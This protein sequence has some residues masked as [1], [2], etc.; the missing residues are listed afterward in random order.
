MFGSVIVPALLYE[1]SIVKS[2]VCGRASLL[3][4]S[5]FTTNCSQSV[6]KLDL[7]LECCDYAI[8]TDQSKGGDPHHSVHSMAHRCR[9]R[10]LAGWYCDRSAVQS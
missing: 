2:V 3:L 5:Q 9:G 10:I 4:S 7:A 6:D 8:E 1:V